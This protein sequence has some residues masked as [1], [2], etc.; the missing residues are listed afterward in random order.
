MHQPFY[1]RPPDHRYTLRSDMAYGWWTGVVRGEQQL[2]RSVGATVTFN[3]AGELLRVEPVDGYPIPAQ[4]RDDPRGSEH[5]KPPWAVAL[6]FEECP[7]LVKRFW[8]LDR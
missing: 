2:L 7:I 1:F 6:G 3:R 4:W 5:V 8:L